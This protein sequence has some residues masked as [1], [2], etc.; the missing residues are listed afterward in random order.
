MFSIF[1]ISLFIIA[2]DQKPKNPVS[3]YGEGLI[4]SYKK[5][6]Q[7]AEEANLDAVKKAIEAYHATNDKYP[8]NLDEIKDLIISNLDLSKYDYNSEN[9]KISVKK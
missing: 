6:Q 8:K 5:S 3:E 1:L 2:C 9:G 7:A 4:S